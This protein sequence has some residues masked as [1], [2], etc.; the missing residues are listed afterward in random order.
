MTMIMFESYNNYPKYI[1]I[2]LKSPSAGYKSSQII[3]FLIHNGLTNSRENYEMSSLLLIKKIIEDEFIFY[4][5][6]KI[7]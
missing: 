1:F 4:L 2:W 7:S 3:G 5:R 6:K